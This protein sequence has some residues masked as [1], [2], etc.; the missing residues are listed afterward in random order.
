MKKESLIIAGVAIVAVAAV[1]AYYEVS[2]S[3]AE[4][5]TLNPV[6]DNCITITWKQ[7]NTWKQAGWGNSTDDNFVPCLYFYPI[8][9]A[10]GQQLH[11]W[12]YPTN[13]DT[14]VQS[15]K[16]IDM[17]IL[18]LDPPCSFPADLGV[19]GVVP[20]YYDF[21][22]NDFLDAKGDL[23]RFDYLR[24]KHMPCNYPRCI[25]TE[26]SFEVQIVTGGVPTSKGYTKPCPPYCPIQ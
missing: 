18:G 19:E 1:V 8:L 9:P 23:I 24:L 11:V 14:I 6:S 15:N 4:Q 5:I 3:K 21:S 17:R 22:Q 2:D 10:P 7:V 12:A 13:K 20:N 25:G 26:L 16:G